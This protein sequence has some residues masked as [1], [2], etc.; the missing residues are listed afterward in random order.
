MSRESNVS[1]VSHHGKWQS[2]DKIAAAEMS[3]VMHY[4]K[5]DVSSS[6]T[7]FNLERKTWCSCRKLPM[8][9]PE[10]HRSFIQLHRKDVYV[11]VIL[12]DNKGDFVLFP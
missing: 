12:C 1:S 9:L 4:R 5:P 6:R 8:T 7:V 10:H 2:N 3:F 11:G